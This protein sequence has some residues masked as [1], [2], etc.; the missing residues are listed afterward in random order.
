MSR[1]AVGRALALVF[2]VGS[3]ARAQSAEVL[4]ADS[5]ARWSRSRAREISPDGTQVIFSRG[6]VDRRRTR[7]SPTCGWSMS[8]ASG[9]GSSTDGRGAT[10]AP[11]WSPDGRRIAFL[12]NRSG[13]SQI[14]VMW[15]DTRETLQLT[16][17]ERDPGDLQ[18]SPDGKTHRL[19]RC[20]V[21]DETPILPVKLPPSPKG[22]QLAQGRGGRSIVR[23]GA[24]MARPDVAR[25]HAR[26]R[27]RCDVGGTPRQ[28]TTGRL[29]SS[30]PGVVG[31]RQDDLRVSGIRKPDAEY[32]RG[33]SEIYASTR[34]AGRH[35]AHRS[36]RARTQARHVSPDGKWIAYTGFDQQNLTSH[37]ASLYMMD[38]SGGSKRLWVGASAELAVRR[39]V[40]ADGSGV[41]YVDAGARRRAALLR[42]SRPAAA[43]E[44]SRAAATC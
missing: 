29:Q 42:A 40:G 44:A 5:F 41:Y 12:S 6:F 33:D 35:A 1:T 7:T 30:A 26:L 34:D 32:L 20:T 24:R 15:L 19:H 25:L 28:V 37:I 36:Q 8:A 27:R 14:H 22:A 43:A 2:L 39:D 18:W 17:L 31:G 4:G 3:L 16:R 38:A 10:S 13:R 9:C 21:P 23:R 11:V